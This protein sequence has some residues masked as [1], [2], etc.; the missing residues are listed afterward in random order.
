MIIEAWVVWTLLAALMQSVRTAGQKRLAGFVSP[1]TATL[2]RYLFGLPFALIYLAYLS[3]DSQQQLPDPTYVFY[4]SGLAAGLLQILATVLLIRLVS[5]RNFAVGSTLIRTEILLTALIGVTL[6]TE[7]ISSIGWLAMLISVVGLILIS[8]SRQSGFASFWNRSAAYGLAAGLAF[9]L[10]SLFLRQASLS[11]GLADAAHAAGIT[12]VYM[13]LLQTVVCLGLVF[14][15][16]PEELKVLPER[17]A[18]CTFIG[19]TSVM[20]SAGGFT[21]MTLQSASYVKTL[22]QIE[23]LF[24]LGLSVFYFKERPNPTELLGM[25]CIVVG[26]MLLLMF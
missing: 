22:G 5:L 1:L 23:F 13:V 17:F 2:V 12:L 3:L 15:Q 18:A 19:V 7:E 8:V 11:L 4:L 20:G 10:T 26:S 14:W 21:A 24:T 6:F 25:G 9:A 16:K